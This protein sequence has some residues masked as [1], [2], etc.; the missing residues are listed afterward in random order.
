MISTYRQSGG[1]GKRSYRP[2]CFVQHGHENTVAGKYRYELAGQIYQT[3]KSVKDAVRA[4]VDRMPFGHEFESPLLSDLIGKYHH[5]CPKLGIRPTMFRRDRHEEHPSGQDFKAYFPQAVNGAVVG[6]HGVS[7]TKC[8]DPPSYEDE[9][10]GFL[11]RVAKPE[12]DAARKDAC[13]E[14]HRTGSGPLQ[15]DHAN[16]TFEEMYQKVRGQLTAREIENWAYYDWI[17]HER[18]SLPED[19]PVSLEF[20]RL[21]AKARLRTLCKACHNRLRR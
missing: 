11:R 17:S 19:H 7:W 13:E 9:V 4:L 14:C 15:V 16:P 8:L 5:Q 1:R 6:W 3:K 2:S 20:R 10:R 21:H 18:F 12:M